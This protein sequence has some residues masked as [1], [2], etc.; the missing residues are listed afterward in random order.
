VASNIAPSA[1]PATAQRILSRRATSRATS[2]ATEP[3]A[4]ARSAR[5][6]A[7]LAFSDASAAALTSPKILEAS[8]PMALG[9]CE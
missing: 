6:V 4:L 8:A 7:M 3:T 5:A 1:N 9:Y 2:R